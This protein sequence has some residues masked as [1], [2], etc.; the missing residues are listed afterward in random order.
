MLLFSVLPSHTK[1]KYKNMYTSTYS[2]YER[3]LCVSAYAYWV[4]KQH[5]SNWYANRVIPLLPILTIAP[6]HLFF[7]IVPFPFFLLYSELHTSR[8]AGLLHTQAMVPNSIIHLAAMHI[9]QFPFFGHLNYILIGIHGRR[10]VDLSLESPSS[11]FQ[12]F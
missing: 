5:Q 1:K 8:S 3:I 7:A 2:I 12:Q 11:Y 6:R 4:A 9:L 10:R